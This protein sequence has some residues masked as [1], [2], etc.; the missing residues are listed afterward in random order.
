M[1]EWVGQRTAALYAAFGSGDAVAMSRLYASDAVLL[2]QGEV[3]EGRAAIEAFQ[4]G[5]FEKAQ[6][7][8]SWKVLGV[9]TV[10]KL[11]TVWG[12]DSCADTP[13]AGRGR[14]RL[15]RPMADGVPAPAGEGP[16]SSCATAGR[17]P[18]RGW[19]DTARLGVTYTAVVR[20]GAPF[21]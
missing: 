13:K 2:L 9:V 4:K 5:N 12:E 14:P 6:F 8:C 19:V 3:F 1:P 20:S 21:G 17:T 7:T 16:G 10:D 11:A 15:E 18:G